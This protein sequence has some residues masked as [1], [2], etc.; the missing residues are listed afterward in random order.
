VLLLPWFELQERAAPAGPIWWP[1]QPQRLLEALYGPAWGTPQP[2]W[3]SLVS[4]C[5]LQELNLNWRCF[6]LKNLVQAWLG[7][8]PRRACAVLDQIIAR[9]GDD[10]QLRGWRAALLA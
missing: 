6:A 9:A 4:N 8:Q 3:D 2:D 5:A 1:A 10:A 7:G